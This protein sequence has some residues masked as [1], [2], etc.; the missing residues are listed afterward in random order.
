M[1]MTIVIMVF[2]VNDMEVLRALAFACAV[3]MISATGSR[4][5]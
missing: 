2:F 3:F 4:L 1:N 5:T